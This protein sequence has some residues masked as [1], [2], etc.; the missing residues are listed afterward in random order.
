M[1]S[2][3]D[4]F[5]AFAFGL[6]F[7]IGAALVPIAGAGWIAFGAMALVAFGLASC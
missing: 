3:T 4:L 6:A 5:V 1:I 7:G 2:R